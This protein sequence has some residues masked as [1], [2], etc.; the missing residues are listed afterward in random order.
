MIVICFV[1]VEK[2]REDCK[3][4][5]ER[6]KVDRVVA[7]VGINADTIAKGKGPA[8]NGNGNERVESA[9]SAAQFDGD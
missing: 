9:R 2:G 6:R 1:N 4:F 7:E 5:T 3:K 8:G